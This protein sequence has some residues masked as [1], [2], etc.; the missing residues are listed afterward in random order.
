MR[1]TS[2]SSGAPITVRVATFN[3]LSGRSLT[4]DEVA[5]ADLIESARLLDADIVGL[6]EVDRLQPR[7]S[8]VD[9][10]AVVAAGLDAS[11]WRFVPALTGTPRGRV[12][13]T[14][15]FDDD[16]ATTSDPTYGI[17]LISRLPVREWRVRRFAPAPVAMPLMVPG[18][19]GLPL[20]PDQPRVALAGLVDG[21]R[22]PFTVVTTHLSIV[23]GWNVAQL[24]ALV[25][26]ARSLPAPRLL[27]GDLNL[28]PQVVRLA[29]G[30]QQL[31][32]VAT[33]PSYRPWVQL[34]HILG[35]GVDPRAVQEVRAVR[36]PISDHRALVVT[37][38]M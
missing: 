36:L 27:I 17:A 5:E 18:A 37:L 13:W 2:S 35:N 31:A 9:Q 34:D 38:Q 20:I 11:H 7:S 4:S 10:T 8:S 14:R 21:P 1:S 15:S 16:G 28:P 6:Q 12:P 33:Y 30:W 19:K 24:R 26:W 25:R 29:T 23:P 32:H 3:L 22:G